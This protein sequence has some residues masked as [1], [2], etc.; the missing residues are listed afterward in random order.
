VENAGIRVEVDP[1]HGG[2]WVSLQAPNGRE[3]LWRRAAPKRTLV[4][5]GDPFVDAGGLEECVPTIGGTPDHGDAWAR[6]WEP[7]GDGLMVHGDGYDLHRRIVTIGDTLVASY[8][9]TAQPGWRFIWAGHALLQCSTAARLLA[10]D[11]HPMVVGSAQGADTAPWPWYQGTDLSR[12]GPPDG[13]ALMIL[14]PGL[15]RIT[16][17]DGSDR[18]LLTLQAE[19][20]PVSM[21]VWRNLGGWPEHA[22][23]RSIGV[24]P[25][26]GRTGE[27]ALAGPG[28]AVSVPESGV[29]DWTLTI[30]STEG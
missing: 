7:A 9:L 11:G 8:R 13:T 27:L 21:A 19:Q 18:M 5:P 24:E 20:A 12:L 4:Q 23:Y 15:P 6:R 10:P 25:V 16:V 30:T 17:I 2:R 28:E 3:W 1:D 14:L 29:V 26:L 22:P